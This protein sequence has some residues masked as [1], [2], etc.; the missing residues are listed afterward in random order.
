MTYEQTDNRPSSPRLDYIGPEKIIQQPQVM[1]RIPRSQNPAQHQIEYPKSLNLSQIIQ[2][3]K[4]VM[5]QQYQNPE[6]YL[7]MTTQSPSGIRSEG[8]IKFNGYQSID[9][10]D[11]ELSR[12]PN[13][14]EALLQRAK[15]YEKSGRLNAAIRDY[16]KILSVHPANTDAQQALEN[17]LG[18]NVESVF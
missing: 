15:I 13:N 14:I 10:L 9:L 2:G 1:G 7:S 12:N 17:L 4:A 6:S 11:L 3:K 8:G 16:R 18:V 5:R